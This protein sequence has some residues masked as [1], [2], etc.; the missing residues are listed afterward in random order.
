MKHLSPLL[1]LALSTASQS[2]SFTEQTQVSGLVHQHV[3]QPLQIREATRLAAGGAVGDYDQDG[4][5]DV[6]LIGGT[7]TDNV[8][9]L[10]QGD[11]T[12]VN[13]NSQVGVVLTNILGA[14]PIFADVDGDND[15]DLMTFSIQ[16][17]DEPV[18]Q[19]LD[20]I[21][22]RPRL[23]INQGDGSFIDDS[24]NSGFASGMPSYGGN[25]ADWDRD[26]DLD[27]FMSHWSSD[28]PGL[29]LLWENDG[30]GH[31]TDAT[32]DYLGVQVN[33]FPGMS[34]TPNFLDLN[35]DGDL[36]ILLASDFGNSL[37]IEGGFNNNQWTFTL[38]QPPVI[39]DENGMGGAVGDYDNDGDMDWFVTS[40]WDEDG[41]PE[42]NWGVTGNRLYQNQGNGTFSDATIASGVQEGYWGWGACFADFNNDGHLDIFHENGFQTQNEPAFNNDP[43]R[44]FMSNGDG[45]F[46]EQAFLSGLIHTGQGRGISC[47]DYDQDGLLD[48]LIFPNDGPVKVFKNT[49]Q[50]TNHHIK[51][52][53]KDNSSNPFAIG[54][55]VQVISPSFSQIRD[56]YPG[57]NYMSNNPTDVHV[58]MGLDA[59]VT[60]VNITWP[61]QEDTSFTPAAVDAFYSVG[62]RCHS[63][64]MWSADEL[65]GAVSVTLHDA[66]GQ[67]LNNIPVTLT[68]NKGPHQG[69]QSQ[70]TTN[71][72]GK[73][74]FNLN[75]FGNG[76]DF[77]T[78]SF[79]HNGPQLCE[80]YIKWHSDDLIFRHGLEAW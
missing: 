47:A 40:I 70:A 73:A 30:S 53:L 7:N 29:M 80:T 20:V 9:F 76:V 38:T 34:F 61:D 35:N 33:W 22:N 10:N 65:G 63:Q 69:R 8:M 57:N 43:A 67:A 37:I 39:T 11:G 56:I 55:R 4:D 54:A 21:Q 18:N 71:A 75:M 60:A 51:L 19:S 64:Y 36:D 49:S 66:S 74:Q 78:F 3:N 15:L 24:N 48:V 32:D 31:F 41:Q 52:H 12:F 68:V 58:G 62:R 25:L 2:V 72:Q 13:G 45:T 23:L 1:L 79:D 16:W 14:G 27:L 44:L 46:T 6:Y 42:G 17:Y 50:N 59:A 28:D 26:G 77:S 5:L